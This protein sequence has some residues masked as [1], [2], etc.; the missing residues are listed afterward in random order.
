VLQPKLIAAQPLG[1]FLVN[2]QQNTVTIN[3]TGSR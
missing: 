1:G 2:P 3:G